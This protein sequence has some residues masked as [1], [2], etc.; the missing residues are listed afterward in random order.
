VGIASAHL[1]NGSRPASGETAGPT[2]LVLGD[3]FAFGHGVEHEQSFRRSSH[4]SLGAG[5]GLL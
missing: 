2:L 3:S 5:H 1:A 4:A